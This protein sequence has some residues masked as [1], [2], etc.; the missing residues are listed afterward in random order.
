MDRVVVL[1]DRATALSLG[2]EMTSQVPNAGHSLDFSWWCFHSI[3]L[4]LVWLDGVQ[5]PI[6]IS[7]EVW[8]L[9]MVPAR[10]QSLL[11]EVGLHAF[12]P[13]WLAGMDEALGVLAFRMGVPQ[14]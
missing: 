4:A 11:G 6:S 5:L 14:E 12:R 10:M 1:I 8:P 3:Q 7:E 9:E 2:L 13:L